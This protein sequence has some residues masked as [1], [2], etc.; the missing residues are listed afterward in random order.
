MYRYER[1][2]CSTDWID[3]SVWILAL[4]FDSYVT[5]DKQLNPS[6]LQCPYLQDRVEL[7]IQK[8][9]YLS[10]LPIEIVQ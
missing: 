2:F 5:L 1:Q 10:A 3:G 7:K 6:V 8:I 9:K 4:P